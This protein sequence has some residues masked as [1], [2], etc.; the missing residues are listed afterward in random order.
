[1]D[2]CFEFSAP[3]T[4]QQNGV[5]ERAFAIIYVR[6]Q[7]MILNYAHV[8]GDIHKSLWAERIKKKI[9]TQKCS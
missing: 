7:A 4:L 5:V 6:V 9:T 1:M 2:T 3:G 8:E